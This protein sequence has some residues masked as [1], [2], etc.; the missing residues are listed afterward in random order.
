MSTLNARSDDV[1]EKT[2]YAPLIRHN[3]ICLVLANGFYE[4]D[5]MSGKPIP[6]GFS[7]KD[8]EVFAFAG[9]WTEWKSK[10]GDEIYRSFTIMTTRANDIVGKVQDPKFRMPVIL[11]SAE[12][13]LWL[14]SNFA[15]MEK[16]KLCDRY[17]DDVM[18]VHI[19]S[20]SVNITAVKG[21]PNNHPAFILPMNSQ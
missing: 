17:R 5:K 15:P 14:D 2:T 16:L 20:S 10:S 9:L 4:W 13:R 18:Q 1:L 21:G 6:H 3:K 19:V 8:R 7:L 12:E 11:D